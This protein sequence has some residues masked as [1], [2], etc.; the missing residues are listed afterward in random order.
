MLR[1]RKIFRFYAQPGCSQGVTV[2]SIFWVLTSAPCI[3]L[4]F[5][6]IRL[7]DFRIVEQLFG[8]VFQGDGAGFQDVAA[9]GG[10]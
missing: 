2:L 8:V 4:L 3:P 6:Q 10:L 7:A 9:G 1:G 5:P